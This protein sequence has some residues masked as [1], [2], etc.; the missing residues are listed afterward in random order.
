MKHRRVLV[1]AA[2]CLGLAPRAP[3]PPAWTPPYLTVVSANIEEE[4]IEPRRP[5][6]D[7]S[8]T[9]TIV[10]AARPTC[11]RDGA[12][13]SYEFLIDADRSLQTGALTQAFGE[14]GIDATVAIRCDGS[15]RR[16]Q[17][18]RGQVTVQPVQGSPTAY[19]IQL[20]TRVGALPSLNFYW[21]V[22]AREGRR[23][24]RLP[25]QG[26]SG[27]WRIAEQWIS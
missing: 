3:Q 23:F 18:T 16:L 25:E 5:A 15:T 2:L 20:T 12:A 14:L 6:A 9:L 8:V 21:I 17:S 10:V 13:L 4:S 27:A 22:M 19:Q 11:T 1:L 26:R 7:R 24:G